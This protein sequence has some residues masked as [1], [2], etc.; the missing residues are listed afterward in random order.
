MPTPSSGEFSFL[1]RI[2]GY[3]VLEELGQGRR[4]IV[5]KARQT[6]LKRLV[7]LELLG[8]LDAGADHKLQ[9]RLE[10]ETLARLGHPN[11][12]HVLDVGESDKGLYF[13]LPFPAGGTLAE[14]TLASV[15]EVVALV[16][17]LARAMQVAHERGIVHGDLGAGDVLL[18]EDGT[19]SIARYGL[20]RLLTGHE[21]TVQTD[22][23]A[24]GG[25]LRR[26]P[27]PLPP[28]L[29][30]I[31]RRCQATMP[32]A[33][34]SSAREL[35]DDLG[36]YREGLRR[37]SRRKEALARLRSEA[38][39]LRG[40][41]LLVGV[42]SLFILGGGI[43]L[44][45]HAGRASRLVDLSSADIWI[46]ARGREFATSV[47]LTHSLRQWLSEQPGIVRAEA[48]VCAPANWSRPDGTRV[49]CLVVAGDLDANTLGPLALVSGRL[50]EKLRTS[51]TVVVCDDDL[52]L[53]GLSG[54]NKRSAFVGTETVRVVG[55]IPERSSPL[56]PLLFCSLETA[57][58]ILELDQDKI[59]Y[60]LGQGSGPET[61]SQITRALRKQ[62][63][64]WCRDRIKQS[65]IV[66]EEWLRQDPLART[67]LG[68]SIVSA[69]VT[70]GIL[71]Q[72]MPRHRTRRWRIAWMVLIVW[73][74]SLVVVLFLRVLLWTIWSEL[75]QLFREPLL[76]SAAFLVAALLTVV[77]GSLIA[78]RPCKR[79]TAVA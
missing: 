76:E 22:L 64:A 28:E 65:R 35:A 31:H 32:G 33:G 39:S 18:A 68:L 25:L 44:M 52:S 57:R 67:W 43:L 69:L 53:L 15:E 59:G 9:F 47:A 1:P 37:R 27:P 70:A 4:G 77:A 48:C 74:V 2:P 21:P 34:Y 8:H 38:W 78:R 41:F 49:R 10:A 13:A 75:G 30:A 71:G 23:A 62:S 26:G 58:Q 79:S 12:A 14:K 19:P 60:V 42:V 61:A 40:L 6:G 36:R 20:N 72:G 56:G 3:E 16:E 63:A 46:G 24:L 51:G 5:C 7:L 73:S 45:H 11:I 54:T 66:R 17:T 29:E 50:R 55:Q